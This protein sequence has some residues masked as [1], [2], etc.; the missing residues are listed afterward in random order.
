MKTFYIYIMA[1]KSGT[2]YVGITSNIKNR[3]SQ[4][5]N[6]LIPGFTAKYNITRLLYFESIQDPD[7]AIAREKQIKPWRRARKLNLI[8]SQNPDL[9]DL[10][11][12][13]F[14]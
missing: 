7:S 14:D 12:D 13:W 4:H 10:S 8:K 3:V 1:N 2:L 9:S 6:K 11:A 5:K